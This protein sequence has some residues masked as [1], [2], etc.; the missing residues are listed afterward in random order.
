[1]K[2]LTREP[3]S[4]EEALQVAGRFSHRR[5]SLGVEGHNA[6]ANRRFNKPQSFLTRRQ[7]IETKE[8]Y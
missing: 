8:F 5:H 6:G 1:M 2:R 3:D 7:L 4:R